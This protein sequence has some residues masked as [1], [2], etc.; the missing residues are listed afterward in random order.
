MK[1]HP[2]PLI[3]TLLLFSLSAW[4]QKD[5]AYHLRLKSGS[6]IPTKNINADYANE[7]NRKAP[8]L[9]GHAFAIIQF[10]HI[11]TEVERQQLLQAGIVLLDY[12]PDN[13][14]Q[15]SIKGGLREDILR[16][17]KARAIVELT[18]EQKMPPPLARGTAPG[19]SIKATGT[20]DVWV[21]FPKV[22]SA[23]SVIR[24]LKRKNFEV[25]ST[26]FK[27]YQVIALRIAMQR[28]TELASLPFIQYVQPAPPEDQPLNNVSR[29]DSRANI[30]NGS[31]S[32]G[33]RNLNGDGVVIG[34][35]DISYYQNH[36]DFA[37][38]LID[39]TYALPGSNEHGKHVMGIA[40]GAGNF[41]EL[42]RGYASKSTIIG[43]YYSGIWLNA[44]AYIQDYGMVVTNNSYGAI[45]GDCSYNGLY[46][47]YSQMLD[48]QM[49]NYPY[50]QHV[51]AVGN[52][53]QSVCP[54]FPS[55]YRTVLGSY[56]S[57]KN[58]LTVGA[59]DSA[60]VIAA[61]SSKGP[62]RD[63]RLK[64][65]IVSM[66][67]RVIS[68]GNGSYYLNS[69]TSM[70]S[71]AVAGG[72]GLLYQ[73]YRQRNSGSNPKNGLMKAI[74]CNSGHDL[75]NSG[76]DF[77][78]GF[79]WL[80]L[81]R[82]ALTIENN[83]YL[84]ST[85]S[86][87]SQNAHTITVPSNVAQLKVMLYWNDPPAS[88]LSARTLVNDLD[89]SLQT[90]GS[91]TVFPKILD[92][93]AANVT[94]VS[95]EGLDHINNIEQVVI[96]NPQAGNYSIKIKGTTITQ[97]SPQEYFVTYDFVPDSM[98]L[99][100]PIGGE[101]FGLSDPILIQWNANGSTAP[102]TVK[103]STDDGVTWTNIDNNIDGSL[104]QKKWTIPSFATDKARI[105]LINNNTGVA[106]M[107]NAFTILDVPVLNLDPIQCEGYINIKWRTIPFATDYEVFLLR[108]DEMKS[109]ATLTDTMYTFSG[110]S[111]DSVY[112]FAVRARLNGHAG[113]RCSAISWQPNSG[114]CVGN[115]SDNDLKMD[116]ILAPVSGRKY[117]GSELGNSVPIKVRIKNLDDVAINN[118]DI[119]YSVNG[120]PWVTENV[121]TTVN[122]ASVYTHTFSTGYDFSAV[123]TYVIKAVVA[124][125]ADTVKANDTLSVSIR[126]LDNEP[127]DVVNT[128][129]ET[130]DASPV[131]EFTNS[132]TG[133]VNL[134]RF[135]FAN[136]S[137][138]GRVRSFINSGIAHSGNRAITLDVARSIYPS[139]NINYLT[140]AFNLSGYNANSIDIR[141]DFYYNNHGQ[142]PNA[143]NS[144]W[145]R[146]NETSPWLPAYDLFSNQGDPGT[147]KKSS[148]I[149]LSDILVAGGQDFSPSFQVRWGQHGYFTATDK[150]TAGGYTFD[151]I[152]LYK[153]IDDI[154]MIAIDTPMLSS[155]GLNST[156]P[157]R[158][159]VRNSVNSAINNIPVKFRIDGGPIVS[160]TISSIAGNA[161][162]DY[163]F[164]ATANLSA[165][166][167][168]TVQAWVDYPT[169]SY[170]DND[171]TILTIVNS[172]IISSFP[173]LE[174]FENGDGAWYSSGAKNS[175]Q[176]GTPI[177]NKIKSAA[178]G[179]KAWKTRLV[180]N[181]NDLE[182]S[183]LYSPCFDISNLTNPTVSFSVALDL[184]DCGT[185]LCDGAWVEYSADGI[186]WTKLGSFGTG[187]N[188]YNKNY[189]GDQLW[190][191]Q[192]YTRWHV[193]TAGL[194]TGLTRL[195]L[196]F[197][198]NADP[199]VN[200]EGIAIDDIHIYDKT[201]G[202]YDGVTMTSPIS[203][204][205]QG[206][207]WIDFV[208]AGKLVASIN[209]NN[210]NFGNT[211]VQAYINTGVVR[212][213]SN[214]YYH[215]RN[216]T[217][218]P[219]YNNL[220]DTA[221]V[222]FYFL[223]SETER[224]IGANT[225]SSCSK[226]VS[227]YELGVAKYND[228]DDALEN[229]T[230]SDNAQGSW[231]FIPYYQAPKVPFDKG[232]YAEYRVKN[233]SEFWLKKEGFNRINTTPVQ[234]GIF[235]V[236]KVANLDVL[237]EWT[238]INEGNVSRFEIELAKGNDN[239]QQNSFVKIGEVPG[240]QNVTQPQTYDFT[241]AEPG[242]SGVRYYRL[243]IIYRD[244]SFDYSNIKS[245][246][247][248]E[249]YQTRVYPN[250]S[251][252]EFFFEFQENEGERIHIAVYKL[253][254][255]IVQQSEHIATGFVQKVLI[256][257][258][259]NKFATGIYLVQPE[260]TSGG[261]FKLLKR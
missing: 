78:N 183:Y 66:G 162:I 81:E 258:K 83:R 103:Y 243:K 213:D 252:G 146:G 5:S 227:A 201:I 238:T 89:L 110:L 75:G 190:S 130:F 44:A 260:G 220:Q 239:Y 55:G 4:P 69:G 181:Y 203:Q 116:A 119:K 115:I 180:G 256:D 164:S 132:Q 3:A 111:K 21:S 240:R 177:S 168:H 117:T 49:L 247:F 37:G 64:P 228:I 88:L 136:S 102:F 94:S 12:V 53:G 125:S 42:Y 157:V 231:L 171:T 104:R 36:I 79:G 217:I 234:I 174:N 24:D 106:S 100:F 209:P 150:E 186:T 185:T 225:C 166:G 108:G 140:G 68:T 62:V 18:P 221:T 167:S 82:A 70:S 32:I 156:S 43:Q 109:I 175:W 15:V 188:W 22:L 98:K 249:G 207:S 20:V 211:N 91:V 121:S 90:P 232:Y 105:Q 138:Y 144:V 224:L 120:G 27:D 245:V 135:D 226:P 141:L 47:L 59:T 67:L 14:Y 176:Y 259:A 255:Q 30:L 219:T 236:S 184:E 163:N 142:F 218:K 122:P 170:R 26:A 33:G 251:N 165:L 99:T 134:D 73:L 178:S 48:Q 127:I 139:A 72:L 19:W 152:R 112:W 210:Q 151:D 34:I 148:S 161:T 85:I 254:G 40:A 31:A 257:L 95:T 230:I 233:F 208:S 253:N 202:I 179:S 25:I 237:V 187:T 246:I 215:D 123:G 11:P 261:T 126:Q 93:V 77:A 96:N 101:S 2:L 52:S 113:R 87:G 198:M 160:E 46:D 173:Y 80:D 84:T 50:L 155:C 8:R 137:T 97:N 9:Q 61:G 206:N 244:G 205:V 194:P 153:V 56:Q 35:G 16:L 250:P 13:S 54:P 7:F 131:Q 149:E 214:Q 204:A 1:A 118:F 63:G 159:S 29:S 92:T 74:V 45:T 197:V 235:K 182:L 58:V 248:G 147:Y 223:D 23:D 129:A 57:A 199:G 51:F 39:R 71:P 6:F 143:A 195:R 17:V 41:S 192:N 200:R 128:F 133:L 124:F 216:L 212:T 241:D 189:S 114:S 229:G 65:E 193:A 38:R 242:K 172:P 154:Q 60:G 107:S 86:S 76:P 196:R 191:V 145:I 169:D 222:R 28:L 10:E 158:I